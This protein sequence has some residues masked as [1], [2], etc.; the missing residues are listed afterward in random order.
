M[1]SRSAIISSC[2]VHAGLLALAAAWAGVPASRQSAATV[3]FELAVVEEALAASPA[4]AEPVEPVERAEAPPLEEPVLEEA[5]VPSEAFAPR[6]DL[7]PPRA[8]RSPATTLIYSTVARRTP[9]EAVAE[10]VAPPTI[11]EHAPAAA[12]ASAAA[13][14]VLEVLPGH[15]PPPVYPAIALRRGLEGEVLLT[16]TVDAEGAVTACVVARSSGHGVLDAAAAAA[17]QRWRFRHGP[18]SIDVPVLFVL[19]G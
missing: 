15:N 16:V 7:P 17:V 1:P 11:P 9:P 13:A 2:S 10:P 18:G 14:R 5:A 6:L 12:E 19:R 8:E 4:E 3:R